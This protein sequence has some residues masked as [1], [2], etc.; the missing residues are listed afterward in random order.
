LGEG[1]SR[2]SSGKSHV[3][4]LPAAGEIAAHQREGGSDA[5]VDDRPELGQNMAIQVV[6]KQ[7]AS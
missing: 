6:L 4:D 2:H 1:R 7:T 3:F 5:G